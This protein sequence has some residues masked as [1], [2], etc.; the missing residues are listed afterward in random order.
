MPPKAVPAV[1]ES[2]SAQV[3]Y[4]AAKQVHEP[5]SQPTDPP[6]QPIAP[7]VAQPGPTLTPLQTTPLVP[8]NPQVLPATGLES[9][10]QTDP[11]AKS[12]PTS[13]A[14]QAIIPPTKG[15][16]PVL[17]KRRKLPEGSTGKLLFP[18]QK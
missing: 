11:A 15:G 3:V 16:T 6:T 1:P 17:L 8:V 14:T 4:P 7:P 12:L 5:L 10:S 18:E 13:A 2:G 9:V